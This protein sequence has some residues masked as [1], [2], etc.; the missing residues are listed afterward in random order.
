MEIIN[1]QG[2]PVK[3]GLYTTKQLF[4]ATV[5]GGPSIAGFIISANL[6]A[7]EKKF[8]A[9]IPLIPA[10]FLGLALLLLIDSIAHFWGLHYPG[11]LPSRIIRHIIAFSLYF[12]FLFF[13]ALLVRF[14]LNRNS[15]LKIFIFPEI[16]TSVFH[17]RKI[18]PLIIISF[19]YLLTIATFNVYLFAALLFYLFTHIYAYN[20]IH[21]AFGNF[22]ISKLFL[23]SVVLLACLLPLTDSTGQIIY[24]YWNLKLIS[25]TYLNLV[26]GYY[27]IFVFYLFL[28]I[29]VVEILLLINRLLK[30]VP[31]HLLKNRA[32]IPAALIFSSICGVSILFVGTYI[33]NNPVVNKYYIT[34]PRKSSTLD[35]LKVISISDLHLKNITTPVFLKKLVSKI[36]SEEPDIIFLPGDIAE[37]YGNTSEAKLNEFI[38]ILKDI[39]SE[40]GI[41]GVR[42]NHDSPHPNMADKVGFYNRLCI[43]MLSDSL[44]ELDNKICILGLNYRG[45]N[46][47][48]P[49]DSLLKFRT[50]DLPIILLDHSPD[51]LEEVY[52]NKIDVQLSGHTHYGQIWPL[53]YFTKAEYDLA[54]GYKKVNNTNLFVSCGVQDAILPGYQ[55]LSIPVRTG[56]VSE[57]IEINIKFR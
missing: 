41:Y 26:I 49:L 48:R 44:I 14:I 25:F 38:G 33:N 42:G 29:L 8:L 30:I 35:S 47:K 43:T 3:S 16:R 37:T 6:W 17:S 19:I 2:K 50:K 15:K 36:R 51:R 39:K 18:Y 55:D 32:L 28:F 31:G 45:K 20:L 21:K 56:S 46:E 5:I 24:R 11:F 10:I 40:Y 4:I 1:E 34:V 57:I 53:N 52:K 54:W 27:T 22:P 9:L 12:L 7:R 13:S 23:G